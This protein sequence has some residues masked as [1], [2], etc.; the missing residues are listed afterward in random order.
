MARPR[1]QTLLLSLL[2]LVLTGELPGA[3]AR[4][5]SMRTQGSHDSV[6]VGHGH[7]GIR[8]HISGT[9]GERLTPG[10][11]VPIELGLAN[12]FP[13]T[14]VLRRVT[15]SILDIAA[16]NADA[17]H[18]CSAADFQ[19]RQM[20]PGVLRVPARGYVELAELGVPH[21]DW[22]QLTMNDRPVNQDGCKGASLT[23]HY[24]AH[25]ARRSAT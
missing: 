24:R 9:V 10:V 4:L 13:R 8:V 20:R 2:A 1:R 18:P 12:P 14:V 25:Q 16:P 7:R 5:A 23:L 3:A 6:W 19:V 15:V 22:P 17:A 21:Q 11:S